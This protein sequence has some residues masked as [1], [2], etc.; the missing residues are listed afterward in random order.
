M[1]L[2]IL[3]CGV[4]MALSPLAGC[5]ES[6][7]PAKQSGARA[8]YDSLFR[9]VTGEISNATGVLRG[10]HTP[11]DIAAAK[12]KL[13]AIAARIDA[14]TAALKAAPRPD[15]A[16][17]DKLR[18]AADAL[19]A[20]LKKMSDE[21]K[22]AAGELGA[23][24]MDLEKATFRTRTALFQFTFDADPMKGELDRLREQNPPP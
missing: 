20:E 16:G 17:Y 18:P 9:S 22:R 8:D 24:A 14:D 6:S 12:E 5:G 15:Q 19:T 11:G 2:S 13:D 7:P 10:V 4:L 21:E 23:D 1:R 3:L